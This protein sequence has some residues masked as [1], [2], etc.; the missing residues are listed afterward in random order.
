MRWCGRLGWVGFL[1]L[2]EP[3]FASFVV[4]G[5]GGR[6]VRVWRCHCGGGEGEET[7]GLGFAIEFELR[8]SGC[9]S[10]AMRYAS[11]KS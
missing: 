5:T 10:S 4:D 6:R 8:T 3:G 2:R 7:C 1:C 9:T 11:E